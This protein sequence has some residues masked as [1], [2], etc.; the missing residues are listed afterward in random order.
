[1][2]V[3]AFHSYKGGTGKTHLSS[4]LAAILAK[5]GHKT[6]LVDFDFRGPNL[7]TLFGVEA[8]TTIN[9]WLYHSN[10]L[11]PFDILIDFEPKFSIP[12]HVAFASTDFR[13]IGEVIR[14]DKKQRQEALKKIL[15][16]KDALANE[17]DYLIID[18]APGVQME[19]IDGLVISDIV[20]LVLK[21]DDFDIAGTRSMISQLYALLDSKNF[22]ILNRVVTSNCPSP[23]EEQQNIENITQVVK[24][25]MSSYQNEIS[26][27]M[28]LEVISAISCYCD[29]ARL[30]S[31]ELFAVTHPD[32]PFTL[33]VESLAKRLSLVI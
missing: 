12:L 24:D 11:R 19:S 18:T 15:Q 4:N 2:K 5:H 29:L 21:I 25:E 32:H 10:T 14:A 33:A 13:K 26:E 20:C 28:M 3:I 9:D 27:E 8:E 1:M 17:F 6:A 16:L 22:I 30:G 23:A 31:R 7:H